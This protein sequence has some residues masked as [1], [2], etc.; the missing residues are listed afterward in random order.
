MV[1]PDRRKKKIVE[2][3]KSNPHQS[4][5]PL[6]R[7]IAGTTM[8]TPMPIIETNNIIQPFEG[9]MNFS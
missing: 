9:E 5:P 3:T 2:T 1:K 6:L 4:L 8:Q 7:N